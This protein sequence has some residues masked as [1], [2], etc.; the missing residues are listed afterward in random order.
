MATTIS[1]MIR[2]CHTLTTE[3][4]A[5]L[6]ELKGLCNLE[7]YRNISATVHQLN[8]DIYE[9]LVA[10]KRDKL[11]A[12]SNSTTQEIVDDTCTPAR[13]LV[14]TIPEDL[15]LNTHERSVIEKGLN[16]IPIRKH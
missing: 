5:L 7:D 1:S 8:A 11:A 6:N 15:Q 2:R 13:K 9:S 16:Y 10:L 12:L 4:V 14:V 3:I